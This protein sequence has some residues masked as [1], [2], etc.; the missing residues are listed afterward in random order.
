MARKCSKPLAGLIKLLSARADED[1]PHWQK[2]GF[3]LD[4]ESV[5]KTATKLLGRG[6]QLVTHISCRLLLGRS[7]QIGARTSSGSA[8]SS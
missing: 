5:Q 2:N 7:D 3:L 6:I 1:G 8:F 4:L